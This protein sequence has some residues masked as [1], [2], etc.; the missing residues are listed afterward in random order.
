MTAK[1]KRFT[2]ADIVAQKGKTP[3]VCL[4]A[5][6]APFAKILDAHTDILL[7][8]DSVGMALYGMDS[9]LNVTTQMMIEHGKAVVKAS[10]HSL[11]VVDLPFGS[12]QQSPQQAFKTASRVM[13][14]TGADAVK[15]EGGESMQ[16]TI[17]F[18]VQ[19]GIP[20]MGHV[21]LMPQHVSVTSGYHYQGR[22]K[23][24][25]NQIMK[26]A[27][28]V[29]KAGAFAVV[30]EA[31]TAPVAETVTHKLSIPVIGIGASEK[32]DGQILV[33][34]DMVGL[35]TDFQPKFVRRYGELAKTLGDAVKHYADDVKNRSFPSSQE[36]V[37]K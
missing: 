35:F 16:E 30:I 1:Q 10:N 13:A 19:R 14:K 26:D 20:V 34:E 2:I 22:D 23:T 6:T 32:C 25:A 15:L 21:G 27:K 9:T 18:L 7:V 12:Y 4:T 36:M 11:V 33:T 29:E 5:Y 3:L 24:S 17:A 8:G 37:K 31:V 28:A